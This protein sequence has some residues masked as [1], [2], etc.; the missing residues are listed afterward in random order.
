MNE[1][2]ILLDS[3]TVWRLT[4]TASI[5]VAVLPPSLSPLRIGLLL[6]FHKDIPGRQKYSPESFYVLYK[7]CVFI[8]IF[9]IFSIYKLMSQKAKEK[10]R[11]CEDKHCLC[12]CSFSSPLIWRHSIHDTRA[13]G[14]KVSFPSSVSFMNIPVFP[15]LLI[16]LG[17]IVL[18]FDRQKPG[19]PC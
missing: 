4:S 3:D 13:P 11:K 15:I 12:S 7:T 6:I 14:C 10:K 19:L 17:Q 16:I 2:T 9:L 5:E 18:F 1:K 8:F